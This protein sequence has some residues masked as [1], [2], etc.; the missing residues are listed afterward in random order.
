[1]DLGGA[2]AVGRSPGLPFA[3]G[4]VS[5]AG[6][7]WG[8]QAGDAAELLF[9]LYQELLAAVGLD[10]EA[11]G[12]APG[13]YNLLVTRD[14]M[15]LVPRRAEAFEGISVNSLGFAGSMFVRDGEELARLKAI[16]PITILQAVAVV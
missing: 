10:G 2:G 7:D 8:G 12:W 3:H 15:L 6:L 9:Q 11:G 14:W 1:G 4:L 5:L 13:A 16:G